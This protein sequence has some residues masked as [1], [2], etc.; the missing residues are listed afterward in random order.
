MDSTNAS[1]SKRHNVI[2]EMKEEKIRRRKTNKQFILDDKAAHKIIDGYAEN[3]I[4]DTDEGKNQFFFSTFY[5]TFYCFVPRGQYFISIDVSI[6]AAIHL[7]E[8]CAVDRTLCTFIHT[9]ARCVFYCSCPSTIGSDEEKRR[10]RT[11][12]SHKI[13]AMHSYYGIECEFSIKKFTIL[14]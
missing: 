1:I 2:Y 9:N 10:S 6:T 3:C 4:K 7:C 14:L 8:L 12:Y 13:N 5:F 11:K